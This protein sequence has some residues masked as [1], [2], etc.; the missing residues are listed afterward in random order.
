[1]K[2]RRLV[3]VFLVVS[4]TFF[5]GCGSDSDDDATV[6]GITWITIPEGHF[7]MG[8]FDDSLHPEEAPVHTV[9]LDAFQISQ[10]EITNAQYADYLN[11]ALEEGYV[12][13]TASKVYGAVGTYVG[14]LYLDLEGAAADGEDP[15][16]ACHIIYEDGVFSAEAGYENWPVTFVSWHGAYA[17]TRFYTEVYG[18]DMGLP[19]EAEWEYAA[20]GEEEFDYPSDDGTLSCE[21]ANYDCGSS[22]GRVT[23]AGSYPSNTWELQDMAGNVREWCWDWYDEE[24]YS[25]SSSSNPV[26]L[27]GAEPPSDGSATGGDGEPYNYDTRVV[28]GGSY[29]S[30]ADDL[31]TAARDQDYPFNLNG[32]TG[33][34][35]VLR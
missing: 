35:V 30:S 24:Y 22:L 10:T 15:D 31:R 8:T 27:S 23:T 19:T 3:L 11:D 7:F 28:R 18:V 33:F 12:F 5:W 34:R 9:N 1:M 25:S 6:S 26:N 13:A 4:A 32:Q 21:K 17:F 16:N 2:F 20:G 29:T 14:Y